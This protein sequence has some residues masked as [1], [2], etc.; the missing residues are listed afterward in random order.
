[1]IAA[2]PPCE[3]VAGYP[4]QI[5]QGTVSCATAR[6]TLR[7]FLDDG[8]KPDGWF[9]ARGHNDQPFAAQCSNEPD[10]SIVIRA[11][12]KPQISAPS[13]VRIGHAIRVSGTG[14]TSARYSLTVVYDK[15]PAH[16]ARCLA[17]VGRAKH[18]RRGS[19]VLSGAVPRTLT[20]Y[21]GLNVKLGTVATV[22]G[23]YHLVVGEKVGPAGWG[24]ASFLRRAVRLR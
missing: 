4:I 12:L 11:L 7:D 19:V 1:M 14:L 17:D 2:A 9:C 10:G 3:P 15:P 23:A 8:S 22:P 24:D 6:S 5:V 18:S 20:C 21:Q 13:S 16:N